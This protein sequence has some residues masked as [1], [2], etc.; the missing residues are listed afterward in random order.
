MIQAIKKNVLEL[1]WRS[2]LKEV[3]KMIKLLCRVVY[4]VIAKHLPASTSFAGGGGY[5]AA[6][7]QCLLEDAFLHAEGM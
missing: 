5:F 1:N 7:E 4:E 2:G 6:L 3:M